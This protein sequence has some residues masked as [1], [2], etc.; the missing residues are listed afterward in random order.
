MPARV[1][2]EIPG[3]APGT[4]FESRNEL[5]E[6]G[7][8]RPLQAGISGGANEG[9]DSIVVSGGYED[10][11]DRGDV[12]VYTGHGANDPTTGKQVADQELSAGNA[13]LVVSQQRGYPVRVVR[14]SGGDPRYSPT[15][16]YRYDGLYRVMRHW[17]EIGASGFR[18]FRYELERIDGQPPSVWA[19]ASG[20]KAPAGTRRSHA[21]ETTTKARPLELHQHVQDVAAALEL[22]IETVDT[23][24]ADVNRQAQD[25]I[26]RSGYAEARALLDLAERL[27]SFRSVISNSADQWDGLSAELD[28]SRPAAPSRKRTAKASRKKKARKRA[29]YGKVDPSEKTSQRDYL[30]PILEILD[31]LGGKAKASEVLEVVAERMRP[32]FKPADLEPL[33]S[34]PK[35]PR[36]RNTAQWARQQL[37]NKGLLAPSQERGV[38]ELTDAGRHYLKEQGSGHD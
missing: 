5:H 10:D 8:H 12:I 16:G 6:S 17:D 18:I 35:E 14:G 22:A 9:A 38:W 19:D 11:E 31:D 28:R 37:V 15:S 7:V 20:S 30:I 29:D 21:A 24:A 32:R 26:A 4:T 27:V 23:V 1:F 3:V 33:A 36:W 13:A 34:N 2:G 25:S